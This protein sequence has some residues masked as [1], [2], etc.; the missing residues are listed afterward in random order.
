[1]PFGL[2]WQRAGGGL[3]FDASPLDR[4]GWERGAHRL[5]DVGGQAGTVGIQT[6]PVSNR[7]YVNASVAPV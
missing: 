1:L 6:Q 5:S 3:G 2:R 7:A 4:L